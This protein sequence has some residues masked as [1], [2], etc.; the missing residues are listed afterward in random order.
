MV[1]SKRGGIKWPGAEYGSQ[2]S[3]VGAF[4]SRADPIS[5]GGTGSVPSHFLSEFAPERQD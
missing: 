1:D 2:E 5:M 4:K 3:E